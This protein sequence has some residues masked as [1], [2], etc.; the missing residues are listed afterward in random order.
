MQTSKQDEKKAT[1]KTVENVT[2]PEAKDDF[3]TE[4]NEPVKL[5]IEEEE[6]QLP[7]KLDVD[8]TNVRDEDFL[9]S[10]FDTMEGM[11]EKELKEETGGEFLSF[12]D[13]KPGDKKDFIVTERTTTQMDKIGAP[14]EK[15]TV[16]A[17]KL[18]DR[19]KKVFLCTTTVLVNSVDKFD[20]I[21]CPVRII[22]LGKTKSKNGSYYADL[23]IF[24]V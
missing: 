24:T 5:E 10:V 17:V 15:Q 6:K 2:A 23:K 3:Q 18:I 20:K 4:M 8:I 1:E 12:S 11:D 16:K 22:F 7:T 13:W 9:N 14:G 19:N 21:P